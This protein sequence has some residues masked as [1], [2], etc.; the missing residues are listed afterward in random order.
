MIGWLLLLALAINIFAVISRA[1][2]QDFSLANAEEVLRKRDRIR[3]H[4]P[5]LESFAEAID[6][7]AF[8]FLLVT[9][10]AKAAIAVLFYLEMEAYSPEHHVLLTVCGLPLV[11]LVSDTLM[12]PI[13]SAYPEEL[14][15]ALYRLWRVQ[16]VLVWPLF[17][18]FHLAEEAMQRLL[19]HEEEQPAEQAE[20]DIMAVVSLSE[21]RGQ[22]LEHERNMIESVL[23]LRD[24]SAEDI[25]TPRTDM[26]AIGIDEPPRSAITLARES[27]HSRLPVYRENRDNI[28]GI[29][30]VKDLLGVELDDSATIAA[31]CR[32][33]LLIPSS[34]P[35]ADVLDDLRRDRI[36]LA[37][38]LDE[39]GGTA[40]ILTLEDIIEEVFGEIEDEFDVVRQVDAERVGETT[41]ELDARLK[42]SEVN[43][44]FEMNLP[45]SEHYE[46]LG[47][48][49]TSMLGCIPQADQSWHSEDRLYCITVLE[50]S[51]RRVDRVRVERLDPAAPRN[52]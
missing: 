35:V 47:G 5:L 29:L 38:V 18:L 51:E 13:G 19:R 16:H 6:S 8:T 21:A 36:H 46:S 22:I 52:G 14:T 44:R 9:Q 24:L 15:L 30:Y 3:S 7:Y 17:A 50:A 34:K 42:V 37:V 1:A 31:L 20:D 49:V 26:T 32:Q 43:E 11:H 27:G 39:Y 33:P 23:E 28:V 12:R 25:M 41:L 40:G 45:E 10:L 4:L 48:L 2:M